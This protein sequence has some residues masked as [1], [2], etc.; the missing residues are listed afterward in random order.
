MLQLAECQEGFPDLLQTPLPIHRPP[1]H[2][3]FSGGSFST[4]EYE[5]MQ[6]ELSPSFPVYEPSTVFSLLEGF[7]VSV[8]RSV[9]RPNSDCPVLPSLML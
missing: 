5:L 7:D 4:L 2:S 3:A 6:S 1:A 9:V 8:I